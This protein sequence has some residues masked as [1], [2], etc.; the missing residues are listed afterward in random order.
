VGREAS[1][2]VENMDD[3]SVNPPPNNRAGGSVI[4]TTFWTSGGVTVIRSLVFSPERQKLPFDKEK[5]GLG[6]W[7]VLLGPSRG[8]FF[9]GHCSV[10][11]P[12]SVIGGFT[13]V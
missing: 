7:D 10:G 5:R 6:D 12:C 9:L 11:G 8:S 4:G 13:L 1:D 3:A 2:D